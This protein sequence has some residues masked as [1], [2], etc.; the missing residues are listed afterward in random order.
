MWDSS[1]HR[2]PLKRSE[3]G[4]KSLYLLPATPPHQPKGF[5]VLELHLLGTPE[6]STQLHPQTREH[7]SSVCSGASVQGPRDCT[8]FCLG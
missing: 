2:Q 1:S 6:L 7:C 5:L 4:R 3:P 8:T